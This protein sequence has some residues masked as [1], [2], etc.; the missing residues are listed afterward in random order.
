M[1]CLES[2]GR[3]AREEGIKEIPEALGFTLNKSEDL[4]GFV[5]DS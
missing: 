5:T 2:L 3:E 1:M 4:W